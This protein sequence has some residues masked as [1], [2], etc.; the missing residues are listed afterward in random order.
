MA[1]RQWRVEMPVDSSVSGKKKPGLRG[2]CRANAIRSQHEGVNHAQPG[3]AIEGERGVQVPTP[4]V[5]QS[6]RGL[7]GTASQ[8]FGPVGWTR[9]CAGRGAH[10]IL[11]TLGSSAPG[12]NAP[13]G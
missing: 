8:K 4:V 7:P 2:E 10:A 11:R 1:A 9:G 3:P 6:R 12:A 5:K 13:A